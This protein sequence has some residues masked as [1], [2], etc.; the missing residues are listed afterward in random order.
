MVRK[1]TLAIPLVA[2]SETGEAQTDR[3]YMVGVVG[4][5]RHLVEERNKW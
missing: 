2:A 1:K 3:V 4:R 5:R